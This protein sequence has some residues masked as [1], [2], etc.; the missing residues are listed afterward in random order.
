MSASETTPLLPPS[1]SP[2]SPTKREKN[3]K[4]V[5]YVCLITIFI[6]DGGTSMSVPPTTSILQDLLCERHYAQ[7]GLILAET[8]Q[9]DCKIEPVQSSLSMLRGIV[10]VLTLLPGL[11]LGVPYAALAERWGAKR[12]LLL[13]VVGIV[14]C[15][16]WFDLVCWFGRDW[17]LQ[18]VYLGPV[19]YL[20]GGGPAVG[21]PLLPTRFFLMEAAAYSGTVLG[22]MASSA[23]MVE[24]LWAAVAL[25]LGLDF[26]SFFLALL[27]PDERPAVDKTSADAEREPA[28]ASKAKSTLCRIRTA[29]VL[30]KERGNLLV[31]LLGY[32]L[33]CLGNSVLM[34][35]IIYASQAFDWSYSQSGYLL[36]LQNAI[37]LVVLL[38]LPAVDRLLARSP[39]RGRQTDLESTE[40]EAGLSKHFSLARGSAL[41]SAIGSAGM[42]LARSPFLFA[43]SLILYGFGSGYNQSIR[44]ILTLST[45]EEHRA[46]T[47]FVLGLLEAA[48]TLVGALFWP[49]TYQ[50]GLKMGVDGFWAG[51]PFVITAGLM[52]AVWVTMYVGRVLLTALFISQFTFLLERQ[53]HSPTLRNHVSL[54]ADIVEL[55]AVA[56]AAILS[57]IHHC[58]SIRPSTLLILFLSARSL[59]GIARVRTLWLISGVD[60]AAIPFTIG[61][62]V[63]LLCTVLEST[64]KTASL[65]AAR[66]R[67]SV[68][69]ATPEPFSGF[70]KRASFAWLSGTF[71]RGYVRVLS[72]EDLP[73]LDPVLDSEAVGGRLEHTWATAGFTFCQPFLINATVAWVGTPHAPAASGKALIGAFALVYVGMAVCT[74]LYGYQNFRFVIRLRGGLISLIH[75]HTVHARAVDLGETTAITLMGTDAERIVMGFRSIHELWASL[76]EVGIAVYLLKRQVGVACLVPAV[77][78]VAFISANFKLSTLTNKFQRLWIEKVENRLRLTS[79]TLENIK[80]VKMLG[81]SEKIFTIVQGLRHA[82]VAT[83]AVFRKLLIGTITL[84]NSPADLAPMATF[85][86]YVIIALVR[87]D[88]SILA[89]QAF[90]SL[91]L[92]SLDMPCL[93][94]GGPKGK[95]VT[96]T[97]YTV[98][99]KKDAPPVLRE[100]NLTISHGITMII[101]P[102]GSGKSTLLESILDETLVTSGHADRIS[103][104]SVAYCSQT[105][106]LQSKSIKANIIGAS[107]IDERWYRTVISACGLEKDLSR[108]PRG[109]ST[110]VG[111]SGIRLSGGQKQ[112]ISAYTDAEQALSRALYSRAE[113]ILL[114]DVFS[115]IDTVGTEI[116]ARNLF[117]YLLRYADKIVVLDGGQV[118]EEGKLEDLRASS[119]Y[120]RGLK[121]SL[122]E[123]TSSAVD[124]EPSE[125]VVTSPD[126][127]EQG[128]TEDKHANE[129][130]PNESDEL[131]D[132]DSPSDPTRRD[133][134][135]S[136]HN[137][138]ADSTARAPLQFFQR[139]D[140]GSIT[141]RFSQDMDLIDMSLPLEALNCL[142][143]VCTCLLK[144]LILCVFARYLA[145]TVPVILITIYFTQHLYLRTSRQMRLLDIEAKAPL[146]TH[147]IELVSGAATIRAFKWHASFQNTALRL[148]NLSQRPVYFLWCIQQC[149]GFILDILVAI[150]AVILVATVV[151]LRDKFEAGDVGV[152]LVMVMTFNSNLM[153]LVKFW[154]AMETSIGAVKRVKDYVKTTEPEEDDACQ[155]QLLELPQS[156]PDKGE[157]RFEAVVAGHLP[158]STPI[159]K[160]LT[161]SIPP[162][163]KIAVVGSSGSGKT[164]LLLA[165]LR[166][167]E[168]Q[169]GFVSVDGLDLAAYPREEIRKRLNVV[170]QEPFLVAGS[171][172]FNIDPWGHVPDERIVA[173]LKRV[174]LWD[175]LVQQQGKDREG[176]RGSR[177][178]MQIDANMF[179]VGQ[180]QLLCLARALVR[181]G[182]LLI[183]DEA[184]S[185]V[186]HATESTMQSIFETDFSSHTI[187]SVLHRLRHI[188]RYDKVAVLDAG[189]LVEFDQPGV[190]LKREGS[191]FKELYRSGEYD[192]KGIK[193]VD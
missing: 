56:T 152:A 49:L 44:S 103:F 9:P 133:G 180:R 42:A 158:A 151:S 175:I 115:G 191:R 10:G 159:L 23:I 138:L 34:L 50:I 113:I 84:S 70:W 154:T 143:A 125:R 79:Y 155:G 30:F 102:V 81:L 165:L 14:L 27:L 187:L 192:G 89:V 72:V 136:L 130:V 185:S 3:N 178:D 137:D 146:Y 135:L 11:L 181:P 110:A 184:T 153:H 58:R 132:H 41:L 172:K 168:F 37:H 144:L 124:N 54:P 73:E 74:A 8:N 21:A 2:S 39:G 88:S 91:S 85:S 106:W 123:S 47:Y 33:R 68:V 173:A 108:L 169:N 61:F 116:I 171:V 104:G 174:G 31:I 188:H 141:N 105:A 164:T 78:V 119:A 148:L 24:H 129:T 161:L 160:D 83:S 145:A 127:G 99:W 118:V 67:E 66:E 76:L 142:A 122:P 131:L 182:K 43:I 157:I 186:D 7:Q 62:V 97:N 109:D 71:R 4:H 19:A 98:T 111:N 86:V 25:G 96:F 36:S 170:T 6:I 16:V 51:L 167:V 64:A 147:F 77:I 65:V 28:P 162:G 139:V 5:F 93:A 120:V 32:M 114:D 150:L 1:S 13:A 100:I 26:A 18:L 156:W 57:Y 59:L 112:R 121:T 95:L 20:V 48:G 90:T 45:P 60:K 176:T 17:P 22:Y 134:D 46:I 82:E 29:M 193:R 179:S 35:L 101:G 63:T 53:L 166:M 177:L 94:E 126:P 149:L 38:L 140:I 40:P 69:P 52:G 12:V 87:N 117:G 55:L 15:E 190:L 163:S 128:G 183:L 107:P 75:K 80:A 92:I 189:R